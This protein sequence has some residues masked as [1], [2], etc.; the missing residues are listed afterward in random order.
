MQ[1]KY[2]V[3]KSQYKQTLVKELKRS[4]TTMYKGKRHAIG[5]SDNLDGSFMISISLLSGEKFP[6]VQACS[7]ILKDFR[8]VDCETMDINSRNM[9]LYFKARI[10]TLY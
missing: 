5:I 9:A 4:G 8:F 3:L 7:K 6:S 1:V 10:A 2:R